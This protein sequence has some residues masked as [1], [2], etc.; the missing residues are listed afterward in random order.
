[1]AI[2]QIF[3][4]YLSHFGPSPS[5]YLSLSQYL[6]VTRAENSAGQRAKIV[7]RGIQKGDLVLILTQL[8]EPEFS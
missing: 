1:M 2:R 7:A 3:F 5:Q 6:A 8:Y 4:F